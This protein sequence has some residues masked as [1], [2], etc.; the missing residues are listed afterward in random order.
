MRFEVTRA[1]R[2]VR[3]LDWAT[4]AESTQVAPA[5]GPM[6]AREIRTAVQVAG[7]T[8]M[9][10]FSRGDEW[11]AVLVRP[12]GTLS[13]HRLGPLAAITDRIRAAQADLSVAA[14]LR[15]EA[16]FYRAVR[17]SLRQRLDDLEKDLLS[18]VFEHGLGQT[19]LVVV[20]TPTLMMVP[21]GMLPSRRGRS[22]TVARSATMW[23]RRH[24]HL[25]GTP[26]VW[27]SAGPDVPLAD[28]E[29]S[30]V[31]S[32]W[33]AGQAVSAEQSTAADLVAAFVAY[34]L[35]HVAAHGEH[36]AQ[37]PLFSSL[38]L[39]DGPVFAHEIEGHRLRASHVVLSACE[40]GRISVRRG[41]EAL[42]MTA[43]LLAMGVPTVVA[44]G[45]PVPD[46]VAHSVM[47]EYHQALAA[48]MDSAS[49]LASVTADG[50]LL[51][52]AFTCYG[53][54]WQCSPD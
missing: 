37:N 25:S 28:S 51:A 26:T 33:R 36:H 8:M 15:P 24:T 50:D 53:S 13:L 45:S 27:A 49:A 17:A 3:E 44:A 47:T 14:R 52:A 32:T 30:T 31:A 40:S 20:P 1:E 54:K 48:G 42:G 18:P 35:V 21:W 10:T 16:P 29:V 9:S 5:Q 11:Y 41:E 2:A 12:D 34:D 38:R 39:G 6:S 43:S 22:T 46:D 23:A 19:P 4:E 7:V